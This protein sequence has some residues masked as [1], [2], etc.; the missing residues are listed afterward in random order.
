[1]QNSNFKYFI[2]LTIIWVFAIL[3][4]NPNGEFPLN[5]DWS[6]TLN[7]KSLAIENKIL[8]DDFGAMTLIVH[9]IWGA[10]FCKL[11]GF[12]LTTLRI[13]TL[14]LGWGTTLVSFLFYQEGGLN[15]KRAFGACLLLM[16][17][18]FFFA[19]S[20]TYMT[21]VPFLFFFISASYFFIKGIQTNKWI[22]IIIST[23]FTILATL[24]RQ[25]GIILPLAFLFIVIFK[26]KLSFKNLIFSSF[27]FLT[28]IASLS[29]FNKWRKVNY[30]LSKYYGNINDIVEN[31]QNGKL[32]YALLH[33]SYS[34]FVLWGLFLLPLFILLIPY[35]WKKYSSK[36]KSVSV[37]IT[38]IISFPFFLIP[39][40]TFM[41][42]TFVNLGVGPHVLP[43]SSG[44]SPTSIGMNDWNNLYTVGFFA[45]ILLLKWVLI[46]TFHSFFLLKNKKSNS[47]D[48]SKTFSLTFFFGYFIFLM[49]NN[50]HI[51][52]YC[53]IAFPFLI[54]L[55]VPI[56]ES[57][58]IPIF[59]KVV[60]GIVFISFSTFSI[61]STHDYLSWNRA[62]WKLIDYSLNK[63]SI[64]SSHLN[65]GFEYK[66]Y[67]KIPNFVDTDWEDLAEWNT[68]QEQY[69][70]AFSK[71][72]KYKPIQAESYLRY[73][74]FREDSIF[75]LKKDEII[76]FDT[77]ICGVEL[78]DTTGKKLLTNQKNIFI[79]NTYRS[80]DKS[81]QGNYSIL[82][83]S[84]EQKGYSISLKNIDPCEK[85][86]VSAW[87]SSPSNIPTGVLMTD[88]L[89]PHHPI[90][91]LTE[92]DSRGWGKLIQ[93]YKISSD[94]DF[95]ELTFYFQNQ[96]QQN[97]WIDDLMI[98]RM[99]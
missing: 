26:N 36:E 70:I 1:M 7:A 92:V 47:T 67:Y 39:N 9:T 82:L 91:R 58:K 5:D 35:F 6:Y 30:G 25:I 14:V 77:I 88:Y 72:C 10:F 16:F 19:N 99:K 11:F 46:K 95:N 59:L 98:V 44:L 3:I 69:K 45:G 55:L 52:R 66:G 42:N 53:L 50:Y 8:F 90:S 28:S 29:L 43:S 13:S 4:V 62:R 84:P 12:S 86:Y 64:P 2:Y 18:F 41:G 34:Y 74:P 20:F 49:L 54:L 63:K 22:D 76:N 83:Q 94:I 61:F 97:L 15:Q 56:E 57:I 21:E 85:I 48:W 89:T 33:Q 17:N 38:L 68:H 75:L 60:A 71:Q 37:F 40:K 96:N 81:H 78:L 24:V 27:P 65:G 87:I 79:D 73:I 31:I 23:T 51:D 32:M 93:E 80:Q